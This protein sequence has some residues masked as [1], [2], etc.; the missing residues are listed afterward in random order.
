MEMEC[1]WLS[2]MG[3]EQPGGGSPGGKVDVDDERQGSKRERERELLHS[4]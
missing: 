2:G 3:D 4:P 1:I